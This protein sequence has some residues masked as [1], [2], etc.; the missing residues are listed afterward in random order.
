M[1]KNK[2]TGRTEKPRSKRRSKSGAKPGDVAAAN[3]APPTAVKAESPAATGKSASRTAAAHE[4]AAELAALRSAL[5]QMTERYQVR[6]GGQLENLLRS[7]SGEAT[8]DPR[9]RLPT[10]KQTKEL[11]AA[12]ATVE[13]KPQKG[14]AKDFARLQELV[15]Q[16]SEIMEE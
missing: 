3:G 4:A 6:V 5:Q 15:A 12:V 11:R 2:P 14:R 16:L 9:V 1:T 10:L 7:V 8:L 13:L